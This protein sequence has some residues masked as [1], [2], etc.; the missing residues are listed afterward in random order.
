VGRGVGCGV[1][2]GVGVCGAGVGEVME[3]VS[4]QTVVIVRRVLKVERS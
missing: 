3:E 2:C 4:G 1:G